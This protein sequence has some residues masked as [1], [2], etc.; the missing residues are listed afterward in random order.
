M[1]AGKKPLS[2]NN[3]VGKGNFAL[4]SVGANGG[5]KIKAKEIKVMMPLTNILA[6][7]V[8]RNSAFTVI[9][10]VSTVAIAAT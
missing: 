1:L 6:H 4:R 8:A 9:R 5:V 7:I 10:D 3:K 2:K